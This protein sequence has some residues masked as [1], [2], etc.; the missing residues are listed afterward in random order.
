MRVINDEEKQKGPAPSTSPLRPVMPAPSIITNRDVV[1]VVAMYWLVSISMVY[2]NKVLLSSD[3]S[4]PAPLFITLFQCLVSCGICIALGHIGELHRLRSHAHF[5]AEWPQ[6]TPAV[7]SL[8]TCRDVLPLSVIFVG[9]VGF[10]NLCLEYVEVSFYNVARCLSLVFNVVFSFLL[11]G[12]PTS[13][14][15]C[16]TL[17]LVILGFAVGVDG[18]INFSLLGTSFGVLSSI[19]VSL[20]SVYTA[21]VLPAVNNDKSL[22]IFYNN[23]NA[24]ALLLPLVC[25]SEFHVIYTNTAKLLSLQ[26]WAA[27]VIASVLGFSVALVTVLQIKFTSPLT[28]NI[29]GTAKAAVQSLLAFYL[30][31]NPATWFSLLGLGLVLLGSAAYTLSVMREAAGREAAAARGAK[32]SEEGHGGGHSDADHADHAPLLTSDRRSS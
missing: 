3:S 7:L 2:I 11:L 32:E 20:S 26:F 4:L 28:H 8:K 30:W 24:C 5:T 31:G 19:F 23:L 14:Q 12:K 22:L 27:M 17:L 1:Q 15:V 13:L 21:K 9:M 10:N 16:A 18:E 29:S 25:L 6:I